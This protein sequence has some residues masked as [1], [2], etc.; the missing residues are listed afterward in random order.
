MAEIEQIDVSTPEGARQWFESAGVPYPEEQEQ[1]LLRELPNHLEK[2]NKM[3]AQERNNYLGYVRSYLSREPLVLPARYRTDQ[4]IARGVP[5]KDIRQMQLKRRFM[6]NYKESMMES[7]GGLLP[8]SI[9]EVPPPTEDIDDV[10][11]T[12]LRYMGQYLTQGRQPK[13]S[14]LQRPFKSLARKDAYRSSGGELAR[15][16]IEDLTGQPTTM[17]DVTKAGAEL[18]SQMVGPA[19]VGL[20]RAGKRA[21]DDIQSLDPSN[22]FN[23]IK[24]KIKSRLTS[25]QPVVPQSQSGN[26]GEQ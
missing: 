17:Q 7:A 23:V 26:E 1:S 24:E 15:R 8:F 4:L 20:Y 9:A 22:M 11:Q 3:P 12:P 6:D 14:D 25:N 16:A 18:I 21:V 5:L 2:A 19:P 10:G 13:L